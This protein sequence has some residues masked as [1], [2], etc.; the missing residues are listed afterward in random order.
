MRPFAPTSFW[1]TPIPARPEIDARNAEFVRHLNAT[2][3]DKRA[4]YVNSTE[5]TIPVY[6]VRSSK[7]PMVQVF[8]ARTRGTHCGFAAGIS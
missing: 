3:S 2:V 4:V 1:N 6:R 5:W 7:V 8:P